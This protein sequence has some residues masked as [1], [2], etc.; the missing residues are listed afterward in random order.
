MRFE[1]VEKTFKTFHGNGQVSIR[2]WIEHFT[3]QADLLE[4]NGLQ[5][6]A[7]AKRL[8]RGTAKLF[9]EY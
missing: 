1:D 6:M 8:M 2:S 3:Y 9:L 7:F 4:L 5:R